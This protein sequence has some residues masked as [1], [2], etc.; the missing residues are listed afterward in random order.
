MMSGYKC[1][2]TTMGDWFVE[3]E[4]YE[5]VYRVPQVLKSQQVLKFTILV[6]SSNYF[7]P[8]RIFLNHRVERLNRSTNVLLLH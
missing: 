6:P 8:H 1:A 7:V 3:H 4:L 5:K 2:G